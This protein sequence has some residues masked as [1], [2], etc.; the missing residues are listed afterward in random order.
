MT[1]GT[2]PDGRPQVYQESSSTRLAPGGVKETKKSSCD[3][4]SGVKKIAIGHHIGE[5]A[6]VLEREQNLL[7]GNQEERQEFINL[8]EGEFVDLGGRETVPT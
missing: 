3:S 5:R 2:G 8:E 7:S 4:R 1:M 6:H